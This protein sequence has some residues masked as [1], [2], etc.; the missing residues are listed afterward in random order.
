MW[1]RDAI[2]ASLEIAGPAIVDEDYTAIFVA[3]GWTL[4]LGRDG[5]L[6]AT[7]AEQMP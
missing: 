4:A 5:H 7:R 3:A 6:V 1:R 2:T